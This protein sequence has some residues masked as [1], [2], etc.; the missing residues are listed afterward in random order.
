MTARPTQTPSRLNPA[1][2][3]PASF[4]L[5]LYHGSAYPINTPE[6]YDGGLL[7]LAPPAFYLTPNY[8]TAAQYARR[9]ARHL[10]NTQDIIA[11]PLVYLTRLCEPR[12]A[13]LT[14]ILDFDSVL[15]PAYLASRTPHNHH[16]WTACVRAIEEALLKSHQQGT[17]AAAVLTPA[18]PDG[19]TTKVPEYLT[20]DPQANTRLIAVRYTDRPQLPW[21]PHSYP[22]PFHPWTPG[23]DPPPANPIGHPFP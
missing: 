15:L 18:G 6:T 23:A 8:Q 12:A 7:E 19:D 22:L 4:D 11:P 5:T 1:P 2:P 9:T 20:F 3:T 17:A 21:L 16:D 10:R 13:D 14:N